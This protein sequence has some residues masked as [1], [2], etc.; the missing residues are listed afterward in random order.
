MAN[1]I[2]PHDPSTDVGKVRLLIADTEQK[3]YDQNK[4][5]RYLLRDADIEAYLELSNGKVFAAAAA[6]LWGIA[7]NEALVSKVIQTEDLKTDGA[8]L[9]TELRLLSRDMKARQDAEDEKASQADAF[10]Y[11]PMNY[12]YNNPDW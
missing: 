11:I 10:V 2:S 3:D 5:L 12:P 9:A 8:K 6:A 7:A 4:K 1:D